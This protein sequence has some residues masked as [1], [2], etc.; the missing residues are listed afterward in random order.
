MTNHIQ[1][2]EL[3]KYPSTRHLQGSQ[4]QEGDAGRLP[5]SALAGRTIVVEEKLDGAN[6]GVSFG[7]GAEL[8][9]QS[10]GHYL[11]GGGRER[12]FGILKRWAAVHADALL[13]QLGDQYVMYGEWMGKKH[14]IFYNHLP[15]FFCEFD[16]YDRSGEVFLSTAARAALL[17]EA[18]VLAV[19]VLFAGT[20]PP[21]MKDLL[22]LVGPSLAKT[23]NWK[24][25][26]EAVVRREGHDLAKCWGQADKSDLAEGLYVKVEEEGV[27]SARYKWVRGDFVQ[28]ILDSKMHHSQQ[29][30]VPNQL[31]PQVDIYAPRLTTTW[32]GL[33]NCKENYHGDL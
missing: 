20:A 1:N 6:C 17:G 27:V 9:L 31:A 5:Y 25:D 13:E 12:Q 21:K 29:P 4:L 11:V 18:P 22:A 15:H 2:L 14:S 10:R 26:F 28:A 19:P 23:A 8:L 16:I 30:F 33:A 7:R 24:R 32:A 3:Y